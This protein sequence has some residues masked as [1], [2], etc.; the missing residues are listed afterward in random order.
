MYLETGLKHQNSERKHC[1]LHQMST[2]PESGSVAQLKAWKARSGEF[3]K[4]CQTNELSFQED[5]LR[6]RCLETKEIER[7]GESHSSNM[8]F[9]PEPI[10]D[11]GDF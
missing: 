8:S 3:H 1:E 9:P 10:R 11:S 7:V 4:K 6:Q 2:R 5:H